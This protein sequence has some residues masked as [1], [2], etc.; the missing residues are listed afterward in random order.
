MFKEQIESR[1]KMKKEEKNM[2]E[3]LEKKIDQHNKTKPGLPLW[4]N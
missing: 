1:D 2:T 3:A 4:F